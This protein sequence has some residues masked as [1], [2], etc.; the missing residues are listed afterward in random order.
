MIRIQR[1]SNCKL[2]SAKKQNRSRFWSGG[3]VLWSEKTKITFCRNIIWK[4]GKSPMRTSPRRFWTLRPNKNSTPKTWLQNFW[5]PQQIPKR[6]NS[7]LTGAKAPRILWQ[8]GLHTQKFI[9]QTASSQKRDFTQARK[10][11]PTKVNFF[12][13]KLLRKNLLPREQEIAEPSGNSL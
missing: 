5:N 3:K 9:P 1:S 2:M 13:N 7:K 8:K 4:S 11:P 6:K 10:F 12:P